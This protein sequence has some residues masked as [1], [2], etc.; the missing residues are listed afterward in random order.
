MREAEKPQQIISGRMSVTRAHLKGLVLID[1]AP[2][3]RAA[4]EILKLI[5]KLR[6]IGLEREAE[7]LQTVL[8]GFS[9]DDR[10]SLVAGP[11]STH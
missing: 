2:E 7:E 4:Q 3:Q 10:G 5:R 11:H 1:E 8:G 6:W 9:P